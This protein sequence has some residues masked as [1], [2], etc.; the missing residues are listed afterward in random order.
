METIYKSLI[1]WHIYLSA[2]ELHRQTHRPMYVSAVHKNMA[3]SKYRFYLSFN[4][5]I[6]VIYGL[7]R[8]HHNNQ[9]LK[10]LVKR[11]RTDMGDACVLFA[12]PNLKTVVGHYETD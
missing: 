11:K 1:L 9:I 5:P 6:E 3:S 4:F 7:W 2:K 10:G 8:N 12:E